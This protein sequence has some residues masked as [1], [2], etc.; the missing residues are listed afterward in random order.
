MSTA[1]E[2]LIRSPQLVRYYE[3]IRDLLVA[4]QQRRAEFYAQIDEERK[5][6][7]IN[8]Q[9]I[10]Q[11]PV[12]LRYNNAARNLLVLLSVYSSHHQLGLVGFEKLLVTLTRNDYEPDI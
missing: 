4:E 1:L 6:E 7:F 5:V 8:G 3:Q 2:E 12:K 9:M 10:F 11:S